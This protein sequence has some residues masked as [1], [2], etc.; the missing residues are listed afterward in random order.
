MECLGILFAEANNE[1][2]N[3]LRH[4]PRQLPSAEANFEGCI[5][6]RNVWRIE[7]SVSVLMLFLQ[8]FTFTAC[9]ANSLQ[10]PVCDRVVVIMFIAQ[11]RS[12]AR[13]RF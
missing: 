5:N 9:A 7:G 10:D 11:S 4:L 6:G 13:F 1:N 8:E 2:R 12:A 3:L